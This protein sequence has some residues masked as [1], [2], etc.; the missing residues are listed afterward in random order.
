M[1]LFSFNTFTLFQGNSQAFCSTNMLGKNGL[2][3]RAINASFMGVQKLTGNY[4]T[5][6]CK[7]AQEF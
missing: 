7:D 4:L 5:L 6:I 3:Q 2:H 1:C